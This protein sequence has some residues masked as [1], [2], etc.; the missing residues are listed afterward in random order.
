[1]E[2]DLTHVA[3][4]Q[5]TISKQD[6]SSGA[7]QAASLGSATAA[8]CPYHAGKFHCIMLPLMFPG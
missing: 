3:S 1:M 7:M 6:A 2:P 8:Q 5:S 4:Y